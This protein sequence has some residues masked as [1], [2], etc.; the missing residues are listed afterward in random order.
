MG[1]QRSSS[2]PNS[3]ENKRRSVPP[4][5]EITPSKPPL[6][7]AFTH[8]SPIPSPTA[9]NSKS[10]ED[11]SQELKAQNFSRKFTSSIRRRLS[12]KG[13]SGQRHSTSD[14]LDDRII[15]SHRSDMDDMEFLGTGVKSMPSS[16]HRSEYGG[17]VKKGLFSKIG[18]NNS[19][20]RRSDS[21]LHKTT[22]KKSADLSVG[23]ASHDGKD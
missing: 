7:N 3:P 23:S 2:C 9:P 6:R 18:R 11:L 21:N 22:G 16:L 8:L 13:K 17:K 14:V 19:L 15:R 20:R 1:R 10:V 5:V 12:S 4:P